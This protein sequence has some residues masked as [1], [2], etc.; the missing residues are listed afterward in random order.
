MGFTPKGK[1]VVTGD[2]D[3]LVKVWDFLT[4]KEI[5][6]LQ[7]YPPD[8]AGYEDGGIKSIA[9]SPDGTVLATAGGYR[10]Q[11]EISVKLWEASRWR[12]LF[13]LKDPVA[14]SPKVGTLATAPETAVKLWNL[15]TGLHC[16][17]ASF[18]KQSSHQMANGLRRRVGIEASKSGEFL[19][20]S[21]HRGARS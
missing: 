4:G 7:A 3:H 8:R 16:L 9:L 15:S 19:M 18:P 17:S 6:R 13:T 11:V 21:V 12:E 20:V 1:T 5:V 2:H 14:F 10:G